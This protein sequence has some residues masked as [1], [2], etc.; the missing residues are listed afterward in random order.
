MSTVPVLLGYMYVKY[1]MEYDGAWLITRPMPE[2]RARHE[3]RCSPDERATTSECLLIL[4]R[5]WKAVR[6]GTIPY[7][8][9]VMAGKGMV[10]K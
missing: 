5:Y 10:D 3:G 4:D 2:S 6:T 7:M 9:R 1:K 8:V